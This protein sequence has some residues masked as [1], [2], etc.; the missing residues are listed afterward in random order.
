[1]KNKPLRGDR[2]MF[3]GL[4]V[5]AQSRGMDMRNV[6]QYSLGPLP[7]ALATVDGSLA[8]ANKTKILGLLE[9]KGLPLNS[10]EQI[11]YG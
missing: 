4:L 11:V 5:V 2:G 6:L 1:M 3:A 8:K 10:A 9:S 7:L